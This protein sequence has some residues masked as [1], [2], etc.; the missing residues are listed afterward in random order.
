M[1]AKDQIEFTPGSVKA[2]MKGVS[3][4]DLYNIP[5]EQIYVQPGFNVR[6]DNEEYRLHCE[7]IYN[8]IKANGYDRSKP[9]SGYI[10]LIDGVDRFVLTDGH[11]RYRQVERLRKEGVEILTMPAVTAPRGTTTEDLIVQLATSNSGKSLAPY[12]LGTVIKRLIAAGWE[13]AMIAEKLNISTGYIGD[14]MLL[15]EQSKQ[16]RDMVRKGQVS[17]SFAIAMIKKHNVKALAVLQ[18]AVEKATSEGRS[19]ASRK[20][21]A[22]TFKKEVKRRGPDL[23]EAIMD[24][25]A[26]DNYKKLSAGVRERLDELLAEIPEPEGKE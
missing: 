5:F 15:H 19:K 20:D 26:D 13:E 11:T 8:L 3:S 24:I 17:A 18:G 4:G 14:L 2:A 22:P 10:A 7:N 1:S 16:I 6:E 12:E 9:I 23:Y 25:M 21:E